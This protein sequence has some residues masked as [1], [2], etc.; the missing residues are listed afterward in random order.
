MDNIAQ[1]LGFMVSAL[2]ISL[3]KVKFKAEYRPV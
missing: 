2:S 3:P 1:N